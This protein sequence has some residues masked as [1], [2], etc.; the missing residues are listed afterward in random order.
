MDFLPAIILYIEVFLL[1][2]AEKKIWKTWFTPIN[3]LSIPY[4]VVLALCLCFSGT[5]GY[6]DFYLP[7]IWVWVVGLA[8]FFIPS[9]IIGKKYG[10]APPIQE[11]RKRMAIHPKI[12]R[13]LEY[14]TWGVFALFLVWFI[15]LSCI[16]GLIPGGERFASDWAGRGFF[17]H[18]FTVLIGLNILWLFSA[19]RNHKRYWLYVCGFFVV[20][21]FYLAKGWFLIPMAG[22]L[23]L[24]LL[25]GKT[26]FGLKVIL[27]SM[28]VGGT[29]FFASYW[30]PLY[31]AA[32]E[33][34]GYLMERKIKRKKDFQVEVASFIGKHAVTYATAGVFGLSEDLA[35]NIV[36]YRDAEV[37][38]APFINICK[39]F[40]NKDYV[41]NLNDQYLEI[42]VNDAGSNIRTF[43][44]TFYVFLGP[45]HA[46]F[47]VLVFSW[48][49]YSLFYAALK[50]RHT[51]LLVILG[52][53]MA[54]LLMGWFDP[55]S[56]ILTFYTVPLFLSIFF[57]SCYV[58][59]H[60]HAIAKI[61]HSKR[62]FIRRL[63]AAIQTVSIALLLLFFWAPFKIPSY[64]LGVCTGAAVFFA[65]TVPKRSFS[66]RYLKPYLPLLIL[67]LLCWISLVY[68]DFTAQAINTCGN[69]AALFLIPFIFWCMTPRFF[70]SKRLQG[71]AVFFVVGCVLEL[72]AKYCQLVYCFNT[73]GP[74]F[75]LHYI[76]ENFTYHGSR[77]LYVLN[78]FFSSQL[79]YLDWANLKS[80]LH[81]TVEA[82]AVNIAFTLLFTARI[83]EHPWIRSRFKK[84]M[85][86]LV[87]L[88]FAISL[89][90]SASKT[91]QFLFAINILLVL[92][93]AFR[94]KRR[95]IAF[96]LLS[97]LLVGSALGGYFLGMGIG[98]RFSQSL[99][100]FKEFKNDKV[101]LN[102]GSLLP[103]IYCWKTA[104]KMIGERPVFGYG[105]GCQ[106][107]YA[108]QFQTDYPTYRTVYEHPH[109]QFLYV[110]L[111][112]GILCLLL[113]LWFLVEALLLVWRNRRVWGWIW[114]WGIFLLGCIDVLLCK[115]YQL[116]F[117]CFP[118][119]FLMAECHN[120]KKLGS[121]PA[122]VLQNNP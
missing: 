51:I 76:N 61:I 102:D 112:G 84:F 25:T 4:A 43:F 121:Q 95:E 5:F 105:A 52:W 89:V 9:V 33:K 79:I 47:Y 66:F 116:F 93:L 13:F 70:S 27:I 11:T 59:M 20:A 103:R 106:K 101:A 110:L 96:R 100:V 80:F 29:F 107:N 37:I 65:L 71:F 26:K 55:Y 17:G 90:L 19:D 73:F 7:S 23:L 82:L 42:T 34:G 2:F 83:N 10:K 53:V 32:S 6:V 88:F 36:E 122:E 39:I 38:Y 81:T 120:R 85:V 30:L 117:V 21:L 1:A 41:S 77:F 94:K 118:F 31:A 78:E 58:W 115:Q 46:L 56:S 12:I 16:K 62:R 15:Y 24:R 86:D 28:L 45:W 108:T 113:Y 3:V 35:Q 57:G 99:Q 49:T 22:G 74:Y 48:I 91:G 97:L 18:I 44:G 109:N 60:R 92:I 114:F 40:G 50:S 119:C 67:Y 68:S 72:I 63:S 87:L 14:V 104:A 69:A 75:E 8:V 64:L 111:L 98:N 54:C